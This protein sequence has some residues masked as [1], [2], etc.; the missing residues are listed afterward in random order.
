[1]HSQKLCITSNLTMVLYKSLT[2]FLTNIFSI[3]AGYF[4]IFYVF[5]QE[6]LKTEHCSG[7]V[8]SVAYPCHSVC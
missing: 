6:G 8:Q 5:F 1:M 3:K 7:A 4:A 2:Y